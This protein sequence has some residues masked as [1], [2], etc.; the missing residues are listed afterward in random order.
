MFCISI[1]IKKG[2]DGRFTSRQMQFV[3]VSSVYINETFSKEV[4]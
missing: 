4:S 2:H 1:N 3:I